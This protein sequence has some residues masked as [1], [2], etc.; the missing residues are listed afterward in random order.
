MYSAIEP[1]MSQSATTA[2]R[3]FCLRDFAEFEINHPAQ[4]AAKRCGADP[5]ARRCAIGR[6]GAAS[7]GGSSGMTRLGDQRA[8]AARNLLGAHLGEVAGF[9]G[10]PLVDMVS[11]ASRFEPWAFPA[12]LPRRGGVLE[13]SASAMRAVAPACAGLR[14]G[15]R[16]APAATLG[17]A[18]SFSRKPLRF[19][20]DV[21]Q[22]D[23]RSACARASSRTRRAALG[24]E[25][26][27]SRQSRSLPSRRPHR[28][29]AP[30]PTGSPASRKARARSGG[31][32]SGERALAHSGQPL[33][34]SACR[35]TEA[36]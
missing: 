9:A 1:E 33:A 15:V 29:P 22:T 18:I 35:M 8:G 36:L 16:A 31:C 5:R 26:R 25:V 7:A 17:M 20:I 30:G 12:C 11:R 4:R 34:C 23:R 32:F 27:L 24:A 21:E 28:A 2:R 13:Q 3:A 14:L 19:Q 6:V 10:F